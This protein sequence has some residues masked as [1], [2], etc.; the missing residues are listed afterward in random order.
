MGDISES[1][2]LIVV[3]EIVVT[4]VNRDVEV[5]IA[6]IIIVGGD[7]CF[8]ERGFVHAGGVCNV[9]KRTIAAVEKKLCGTVLGDHEQIQP[10]IVI[11]IRPY[12][13]LSC[14]RRIGKP[15]LLGDITECAVTIPPQE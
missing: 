14:S 4:T 10:T 15:G 13:T 9:L 8:A 1:I 3:V 11:Y 7:D 5:W 2:V 6:V 12:G